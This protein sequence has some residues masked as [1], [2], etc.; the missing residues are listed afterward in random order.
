MAWK[1]INNVAYERQERY[2]DKSEAKDPFRDAVGGDEPVHW[3][4]ERASVATKALI[5]C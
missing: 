5:I 2:A 4:E 3:R 1:K